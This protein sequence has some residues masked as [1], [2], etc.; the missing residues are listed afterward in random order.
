MNRCAV[1]G[2]Q[3][4]SV[5]IRL[6]LAYS[7]RVPMKQTPHK[8]KNAADAKLGVEAGDGCGEIERC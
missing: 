4:T 8:A 3:H 2:I 6:K 5:A 7:S 1:P